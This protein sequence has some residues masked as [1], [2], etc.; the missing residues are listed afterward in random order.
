MGMGVNAGNSDGQVAMNPVSSNPMN[1]NPGVPQQQLTP[2]QFLQNI[3]ANMG[4]L[5]RQWAMVNAQP[6][7]PNK[8]AAQQYLT[9]QMRRLMA[10]N[11]TAMANARSS[12]G[13]ANHPMTQIPPGSTSFVSNQASANMVAPPQVQMQMQM[14]MQGQPS[15]SVMPQ[16]SVQRL[17]TQM[18]APNVPIQSFTGQQQQQAHQPQQMQSQSYQTTAPL[19]MPSTPHNVLQSL[20]DVKPTMANVASP[21]MASS[22][23]I[24]NNMGTQ[25]QPQQDFPSAV[26]LFM[27]QRGINLPM[28]W[29]SPFVGPAA[30]GA[31][32][33]TRSI[34]V[35]RLFIKVMTLGGSDQVFAIPNGWALVA[36]QLE[37]AVGAPGEPSMPGALMSPSE[38][39]GR[40]AAYYTQRLS[41][42]EKSWMATQ[43]RNVQPAGGP[44]FAPN[45]P[46]MGAMTGMTNTLGTPSLA[47]AEKRAETPSSH[48]AAAG[49]RAPS[50]GPS[51]GTAT[52][53]TPTPSNPFANMDPA[54]V[55]FAVGK[56]ISQLQ[57]L[58]SS[59]QLPP[60]V[61]MARYTAIQQ[62][63]QAYHAD[64]ANK[65]AGM[66]TPPTWGNAAA[67]P[68]VPSGG[69]VGPNGPLPPIMQPASVTQTMTAPSPQS[70]PQSVSG[71]A[72]GGPMTP[73]NAAPGQSPMMDA[74]AMSPHV[75][76]PGHAQSQGPSVNVSPG[77]THVSANSASPAVRP[78]S[79]AGGPSVSPSPPVAAPTPPVV[80]APAL[81]TGSV[82][83]PSPGPALAT[84]VAP[85]SGQA[86]PAAVASAAAPSPVPA[87]TSHV[88]QDRSSAGSRSGLP[89]TAASTRQEP[90]KFKIE[91]VPTNVRMRTHGGR[92]LDRIDRE[93]VPRMATR[94]RPRGVHELGKVDVY[95]LI[96]SLQSGLAHEISY[97]L[98]TLL[99]LSSGLDAPAQFRFL[100]APCE[101]LL[102]VLLDMLIREMG[103]T[104]ESTNVT[105]TLLDKQLTTYCEAL[106]LALQDEASLRLWRRQTGSPVAERAANRRV[107]VVQV[108]FTILRNVSLMPENNTFLATHARFVPSLAWAARTIQADQRWGGTS[109]QLQFFSLN[110]L[111]HLRKDLV[112][113]LLGVAGESLD[114]S[115]QTP[116]TVASLV[117]LIRFFVL[118]A[119][120][121]EQRE[122]APP[123]LLERLPAH[124]P[125]AQMLLYQVPHH[126][127]LAL[128]AFSCFALPDANRETLARE[129]PSDV[130]LQMSERL[131]S[132]LPVQLSDFR[133]LESSTRLGYA[134]AVAMCLY[135][136]VYLAPPSVKTAIRE[137]PG[138]VGI[139]FRAVKQLL[140]NAQDYA[141]NPYGLLCRRLTEIMRLLSDGRGQFGEPPL[142]GMYWP[143]EETSELSER[144]GT[145]SSTLLA[146]QDDAVIEMLAR[147]TNVDPNMAN[148]LLTLVSAR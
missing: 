122:G 114:L 58:V 102:D 81:P 15:P 59:G 20:P 37:L 99:I 84:S 5:Q 17:A 104:D 146:G 115:A 118:D 113:I 132:L 72:P 83:A 3:Q 36:Q 98:N 134:E 126:A 7:G 14:Q 16:G 53:N 128:Q 29:A 71:M 74:M 85:A 1:Q 111:L 131:L 44:S 130:L 138:A 77:T 107:A 82:T 41:L 11:E 46:T 69:A 62:A 143:P 27:S 34:D 123:A 43:Q 117:D 124:T 129:I 141:R 18:M 23:K 66:S 148:E 90:T 22:P 133:R 30:G 56:H 105:D 78:S 48:G 136:V 55:Q 67:P 28:D 21:Q 13:D 4:A 95:G 110:E 108:I 145:G 45:T 42:F 47:G 70:I 96:M 135:N 10:M 119:A 73:S 100:M 147:T 26:R 65:E 139:L 92:D 54:Q 39:P 50:V 38:V 61:A 40:L 6:D 86:V 97:A 33:E 32:G 75:P 87:G 35:Q 121:F 64:R 80:P 68:V 88:A 106:E 9:A 120:E 140:Q 63:L 49:E 79:V 93:L 8:T 89:T 91:Y 52:T 116:V 51:P 101:N 25:A 137:T 142:L 103:S 19:G 94:T 60:Q 31:P 144:S 24:Q 76:L 12:A 57:T 125:Q 2:G 127:Q 112:T 109:E